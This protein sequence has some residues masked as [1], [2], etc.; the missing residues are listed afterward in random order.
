MTL[1]VHSV[2]KT[3]RTNRHSTVGIGIR[4]AEEGN[5]VGGTV[6]IGTVGNGQARERTAPLGSVRDRIVENVLV[7][8][9]QQFS[10]E[11]VRL[12]AVMPLPKAEAPGRHAEGCGRQVVDRNRD[13]SA[14]R[15][16]WRLVQSRDDGQAGAREGQVR[17]LISR[18]SVAP[19]HSPLLD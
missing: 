13:W 19:W 17:V 16:S 1:N 9:R 15:D 2:R 7:K 18:T 4:S 3:S 11:D 14:R 5:V 10:H 8:G 12:T 6:R